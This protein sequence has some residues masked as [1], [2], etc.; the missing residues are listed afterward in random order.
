MT[1]VDRYNY[2]HFRVTHLLD[3]ARG[4]RRL[5]GPAPGTPAPDFVLPDTTGRMWRLSDQRP[6]P[7]VLHFGSFT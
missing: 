2:E 6:R 1:A 3:D 4:V 5:R 7:V